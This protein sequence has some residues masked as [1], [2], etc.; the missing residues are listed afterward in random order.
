MAILDLFSRHMLSWKLSNS[1]D[2]EFYVE[3][4]EIAMAIG[5]KPQIFRSDQGCKF[6]S[7]GFVQRLK[8]EEIQITWSGRRRFYTT[9]WGRSCGA[10]L[11]TRR[12]ACVRRAM[13]GQ[14][15]SAWPLLLKRC[16]CE[17]AQHKHI[18]RQNTP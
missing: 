15:R 10:P 6:T 7:S 18:G 8:E 9:S 14:R 11:G 13:S 16:P 4:L 3:A 12:C 5:R 2:T 17:A 1:L